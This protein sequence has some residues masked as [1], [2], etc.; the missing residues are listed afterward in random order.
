MTVFKP[1]PG[2][3]GP[4]GVTAGPGGTWFSHGATIDRIRR[5]RITEFA[6]PDPASADTGWLTWDGGA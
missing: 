1:P 2:T 4:F 5:G 3:D 6:V